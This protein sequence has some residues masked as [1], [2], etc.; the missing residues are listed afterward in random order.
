MLWVLRLTKGYQHGYDTVDCFVVRAESEHK[1]RILASEE[2]SMEDK[3]TW[4]DSDRTTCYH[5][6]DDETDEIVTCDHTV[7]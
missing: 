4:L 7:V 2:T 6:V 3:S 5:L 1:A